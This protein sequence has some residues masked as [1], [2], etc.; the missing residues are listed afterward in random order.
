MITLEGLQNQI[1]DLDGLATDAKSDLVA[2]INEVLGKLPADYVTSVAG[3]TG[4]VTLDAANIAAD[5]DGIPDGNVAIALA[6]LLN[7]INQLDARDILSQDFGGTVYDVLQD[8]IGDVVKLRESL[9][10][11]NASKIPATFDD[12]EDV[13]TVYDA[14]LYLQALAQ[15]YVV[16]MTKNA[17]G[18]YTADKTFA[19]LKAA[20]DAGKTVICSFKDLTRQ[21]DGPVRLP[22][23][24]LS[25]TGMGFTAVVT[26]EQDYMAYVWAYISSGGM[27]YTATEIATKDTVSAMIAAAIGDTATALSDMDSVIGGADA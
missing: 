22:L 9:L 13:N 1:G 16:N 8:L 18:T 14:L 27:G 19:E 5:V 10:S 2:A 23:V 17:D 26:P 21:W 24:Y 7:V 11:L 20:H 4:D 15:P 6:Y 25:D 12:V 3:M